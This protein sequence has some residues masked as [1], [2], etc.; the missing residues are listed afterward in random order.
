[1][2]KTTKPKLLFSQKKT[3]QIL[4]CSGISKFKERRALQN[5]ASDFWF[6]NISSCDSKCIKKYFK[7]YWKSE[8]FVWFGQDFKTGFDA[9]NADTFYHKF[10]RYDQIWLLRMRTSLWIYW[11]S[12]NNQETVKHRMGPISLGAQ[13]IREERG[14]WKGRNGEIAMIYY[15]IVINIL[16]WGLVLHYGLWWLFIWWFNKWIKLSSESSG[17]YC[18]SYCGICGSIKY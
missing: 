1:M 12:F 16:W 11:S 8:S 3:K 5:I 6:L 4:F 10:Y 15:T 13:R 7:G 9:L 14:W 18:S 2:A 17:N